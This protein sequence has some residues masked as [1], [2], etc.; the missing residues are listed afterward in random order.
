[1]GLP[2]PPLQPELITQ[3]G[4]EGNNMVGRRKIT[5]TVFR[6][7]V[8]PQT[9]P[10]SH[11]D[12][13]SPELFSGCLLAFFMEGLSKFAYGWGPNC[14]PLG[15]LAGTWGGDFGAGFWGGFSGPNSIFLGSQAPLGLSPKF[16]LRRGGGRGNSGGQLHEKWVFDGSCCLMAWSQF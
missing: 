10:Q 13:K 14:R 1:M 8:P 4:A 15:H 3:Q 7:F 11:P 2:D 6:P 16:P 9:G 12:G 5:G